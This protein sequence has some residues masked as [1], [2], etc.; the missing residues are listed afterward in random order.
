MRSRLFGSEVPGEQTLLQGLTKELRDIAH[1]QAA[2]EIE[3]VNLD[4]PDADGQ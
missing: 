2:H 1:I 3:A 4:C